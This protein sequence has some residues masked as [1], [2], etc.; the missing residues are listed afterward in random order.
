VNVNSYDT[1]YEQK[2]KEQK[3]E[4]QYVHGDPEI[5]K[6]ICKNGVIAKE[7]ERKKKRN[8]NQVLK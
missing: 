1:S 3:Q 7:K 2:G 8:G 5:N 4:I 6:Q